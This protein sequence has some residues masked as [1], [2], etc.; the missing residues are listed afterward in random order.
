M[1]C[2]YLLSISINLLKTDFDINSSVD[3][4]IYHFLSLSPTLFQEIRLSMAENHPP[5]V[6]IWI[7][8]PLK[9]TLIVLSCVYF[10]MYHYRGNLY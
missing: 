10:T 5:I 6:I 3:I 9:L 7:G 4:L 2:F 1:R 8:F